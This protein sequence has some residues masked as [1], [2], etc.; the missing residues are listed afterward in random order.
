[1]LTL[2]SSESV[3]V[4][5]RLPQ[6]TPSQFPDHLGRMAKIAST[7]N[8]RTSYLTGK[9]YSKCRAFDASRSGCGAR[10]SLSMTCDEYYKDFTLSDEQSRKLKRALDKIDNF[11][12]D[13]NMVELEQILLKTAKEG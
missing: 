10:K 2:T 13:Y 6:T 11:R 9:Q 5:V 8:R 1:M 4:S 7:Y 12:D 3:F